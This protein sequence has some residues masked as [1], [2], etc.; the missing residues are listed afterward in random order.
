[1]KS[2]APIVMMLNYIAATL[3]DRYNERLKIENPRK[4]KWNP[5]HIAGHVFDSVVALVEAPKD[6]KAAFQ[7]SKQKMDQFHRSK[8]PPPSPFSDQISEESYSSFINATHIDNIQ[9]SQDAF[10]RIG[11]I[12]DFKQSRTSHRIAVYRQTLDIIH[13]ASESSK[14]SD[15]DLF[16][17]DEV[18]NRPDLQDVLFS[19]LIR[20]ACRVKQQNVYQSVDRKS[21]TMYILQEGKNPFTREPMTLDMIEP[22]P[23]LQ[24][25][26]DAFI[27]EK[28]KQFEK[29]KKQK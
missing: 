6:L 24:A 28:K 17:D 2:F 4:F 29:I 5:L 3:T 27:A 1:S 26:V 21:I 18:Q 16:L 20:D 15:F 10:N 19:T 25:K 22:D 23:E 12:I 11:D 13:K 7:Q 14:A 9:F 8:S